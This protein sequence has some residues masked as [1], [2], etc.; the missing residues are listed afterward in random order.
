MG[1]SLLSDLMRSDIFTNPFKELEQIPFGIERDDEVIVSP[2]RVD[3]KETSDGHV[4][5]MD[6]PGMKKEELKIEVEENRVLRV[7]GE[8]KREKEERDS[9]DHWHRCERS[10]GKFWRQFRLPENVDLDKV[11]A[12][13]EDGVLTVSIGK[14]AP[15][16]IKGS[17]VVSIG[18]GE[19]E[20]LAAAETKSEL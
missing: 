14:L 20:R 3:W 12:K 1:T 16:R 2:A 9:G 7:S 4:I 11:N 17:K 8:R 18:G 5:T 15:D 10:Y 13:L 6:V 19:P